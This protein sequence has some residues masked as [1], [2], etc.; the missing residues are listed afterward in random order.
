MVEFTTYAERT[1]YWTERDWATDAPVLTASRIEV[2]KSLTTLLKTR[3]VIAGV[4]W[5][6]HRGIAK[7]EIRI[8]RAS[9]RRPLWPRTVASTCGGSGRSATSVRRGCTAPRSGPPT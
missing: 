6:Q 7:V 9:A 8:D 5:A 2:P 1:A 3:P 4:A